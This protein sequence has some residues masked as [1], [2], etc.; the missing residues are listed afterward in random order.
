MELIDSIPYMYSLL[1]MKVIT[2]TQARQNLAS[3]MDRVCEDCAP[4]TITRTGNQQEV[5][6][7]SRKEYD[8][9]E[10]TAYLLRSPANARRLLQAIDDLSRGKGRE[11]KLTQK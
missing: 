4:V 9:I 7:L 2:Y 3:T 10:E 5:V 1:Y 6:M 8:Q 11:R